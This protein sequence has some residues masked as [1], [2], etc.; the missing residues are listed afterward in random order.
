MNTKQS[1]VSLLRVT[2]CLLLAFPATTQ[3]KEIEA[4]DEWTKLGENDTVPAG[5]HVRMDL[6]SGGRW[7]KKIDPNEADEG[8]P[9]DA[10]TDPTTGVAVAQIDPNG[11]VDT[12]AAAT[13]DPNYD[14]TMMHRTLSKLP[15]EEQARIGGIPKIP[16]EVAA[17]VTPE[18]RAAFEKRMKEIWEQRQEE[19]K[20][21]QEDHLADLPQLLR[22]RIA[23]I[24][25][26][27]EDPIPQLQALDL[28]AETPEDEIADIL[29]VLQDLEFQLTDVDMARDF[30]TLG[31]WPLLSSLLA[32]AV[33]DNPGSNATQQYTMTEADWNKVNLIQA[34][35]A[36]TIGTAVKNTGEF[37]PYATVEVEVLHKIGLD[38]K[39]SSVKTTAL[40][41]VLAQF[42]ASSTAVL[43][44]THPKDDYYDSVMTKVH[45]TVYALGALLRANRQAQTHF[46]A[47]QGPTLLA[48]VL[49][50]LADQANNIN[51]PSLER[52]SLKVVQRLLSLA[53]D[54]V[55]D[56]TLHASTSEQVDG[57][58]GKAFTSPEWCQT[59]LKFVSIPRL[60]E[61]TLQ[62]IQQVA[63]HCGTSWDSKEVA[64]LVQRPPSQ[65][66]K[67]WLPE[68]L[69]EDLKEERMKLLQDTVQAIQQGE[70]Q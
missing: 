13:H 66:H 31:G 14:Y 6:T 58:I 38:D 20:A 2:A 41:L 50:Q 52:N 22:D 60:Y 24:K 43:E 57:A 47:D 7:V 19:L 5:V 3:S 23:S 34:H 54:I 42:V 45:K 9:Q 21:F 56:V 10:V 59:L 49:T 35:A 15:P 26:Y 64:K 44:T 28:E 25:E 62:T 65:L 33:H 16:E 30:Y 39:A 18:Q 53:Q 46:C 32:D 63:P 36:W 29:G 69:D 11:K 40:D 37:A 70:K 4:T 68:D 55:M 8:A 1:L 67:A 12:G 27:L 17:K 61:T 51:P 48:N